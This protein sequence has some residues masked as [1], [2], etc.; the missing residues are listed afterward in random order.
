MTYNLDIHRFNKFMNVPDSMQDEGGMKARE[1]ITESGFIAQEV[2]TAAKN[3]GIFLMEWVFPQMT[4]T[5]TPWAI[6]LSWC[7]W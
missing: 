6:P 2:E 1:A 7:R 5:L 3:R 4:K